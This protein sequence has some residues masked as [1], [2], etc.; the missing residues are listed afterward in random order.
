MI[1]PFYG[2][3]LLGGPKIGYKPILDWTE[4]RNDQGEGLL[5]GVDV[6]DSANTSFVETIP[7]LEMQAGLAFMV[8]DEIFYCDN[9]HILVCYVSDTT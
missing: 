1:A 9:Y 2:Q 4:L 3:E 5:I 6:F 7:C 8:S